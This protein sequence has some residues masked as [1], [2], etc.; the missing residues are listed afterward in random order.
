MAGLILCDD[1]SFNAPNDNAAAN[2]D[3]A[4]PPPPD[5]PVEET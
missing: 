2:A 4:D 5:E 3:E 1:D